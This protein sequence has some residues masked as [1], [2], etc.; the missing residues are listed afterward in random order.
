MH[1]L[2]SA[3]Q[4]RRQGT[5]SAAGLSSPPA[6]ACSLWRMHARMPGAVLTPLVHP[7]DAPACC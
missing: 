6:P 1:V 2:A 3:S 5:P 4:T 7:V